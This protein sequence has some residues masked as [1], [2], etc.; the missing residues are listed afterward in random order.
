[1]EQLIINGDELTPVAIFHRLQG[2]RKVLLESRAEGKHGRYSIIAANPVETIR[3]DG[4]TV[5]NATGTVHADDPLAV[6]STLIERDTEDA[7]YPFIGGAVGYIGY[8]LLRTYE[9]IPNTPTETRDLPDALFQRYET[10][11]LYD[12]LEERVILIDTGDSDG[13]DRLEQLK[14]ELE[15][16]KTHELAPVVRTSERILTDKDAFIE[17][18]LKAKEAILA[19]E[20]FQL[21]LSQRID[22]KFTGDP[23]HFYRTLRKLNPS[24]YLFYIDLGEAIVLG[25]SPES[26]VRVEGNRVST[27]P[28][29]GTRPRGKTVEEDM[30]HAADLIED[31]KELA[32]HRMLLDLG[33]ND[34]GRVAKVGTVT[35]PKQMEVERFKNVMHLVSEVEG[36]LRD[37][38]NPIDALRA[39]L[40]AGTVSGAPKIRAMQLIDELETLKREV[41]AGAVGYLDVRGGFDFALAIRTMV[42]QNDTAYVQAG[43]GIVFDSDPV[44]EYEETLHK[45]KSLLEV[46]A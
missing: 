36:E 26:L 41:Y 23:F 31:E 22:A 5:T 46:F 34:I 13:T 6:L 33:R 9:P 18:V 1:M 20:V 42:V 37:D 40:P 12:H 29:A 14:I 27:N 17:R 15:T 8:D 4:N 30:R 16:A 38:L 25:A 39:C 21:V 32:E 10:V 43:A 2:E 45:A 24:P 28:I 44:S 11:V 35:I 3:V 19:G 7:P